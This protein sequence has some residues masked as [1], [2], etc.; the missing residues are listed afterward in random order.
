MDVSLWYL[1]KGKSSIQHKYS[2]EEFEQ[3]RWFRPE[4]IPYTLSD[5]HMRRLIDKLNKSL[6]LNSYEST[7]EEYA[8]H[9]ASLHPH[10]YA[11]KFMKMLPP[12]SK[13]IDI[14]CGPGRDAKIF[15]QQ[16]L[17]VTGIDFSPK[18]IAM[19]KLN[20][21]QAEFH[22]MDIEKLNFPKNTFDGVWAS[23]SFLHIP[24][25]NM[26]YVLN[27]IHSF[28]KPER[29]FYLSVKKG[30]NE[31]LTQDERYGN[32]QKFWAFFEEQELAKLLQE[33]QFEIVE[34]DRT[35]PTSSYETHPMIRVFCKKGVEG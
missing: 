16:G 7:T 1:L 5:P 29:I 28:L 15:Q 17:K 25:K 32:Q 10:L 4:E 27:T 26:P 18:M 35:H 9:T 13:I 21:P 11:Q 23:A 31:I 20:T 24:K 33:A 12:S 14:G 22:V 2:I 19:A 34:M 8:T 6:T 3:I 30:T